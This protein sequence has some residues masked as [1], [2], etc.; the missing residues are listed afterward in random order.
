MSYED[1]KS[2]FTE[3]LEFEETALKIYGE[4]YPKTE[5][6]KIRNILEELMRDEARHAKNA[7]TVLSLLEE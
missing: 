3:I 2:M 1:I 6:K 7:R 4:I 5:S